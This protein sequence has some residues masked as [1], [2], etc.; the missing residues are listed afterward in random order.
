MNL[1]PFYNRE[2]ELLDTT[3]HPGTKEDVLVLLGHG[4]TGNKDRP[5]L[6]AVAEGLSKRGWPC[7]RFSYSGNGNSEGSFED[8]NITKEVADLSALID[9]LPG[10]LR[11]AYCGHSMGGAVGVIAAASNPR[12]RVLV[13]LAGMVYTANFAEREFDDVTPGEGLMWDEPGC[14]LSQAYIDDL[15]AIG[16]TLDVAREIEAPWLLVHGEEDDVIP[17]LDSEDAFEATPGTAHLVKIPGAGHV[18]DAASYGRIVE[19]MDAW[20]SEHLK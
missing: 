20:L 16:D 1:P 18:F 6:I 3:F 15:H 2:N 4:V 10:N 13:T 19:E 8:S 17:L 9:S 5:L 11:I 7:L 12:I 14:P